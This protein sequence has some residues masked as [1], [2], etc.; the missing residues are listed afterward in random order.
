MGC[1][2][3]RGCYS[4]LDRS[5][6]RSNKVTAAGSIDQASMNGAAASSE[7]QLSTIGL[8][9]FIASAWVGV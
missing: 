2:P 6:K 5:S 7:Q 8:G 1:V 3:L 9:I 4:V